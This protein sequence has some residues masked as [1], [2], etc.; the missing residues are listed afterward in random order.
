[1]HQLGKAMG[2]EL[3]KQ[4]EHIT[5]VAKKTDKVD[6]EIARNRALLDRF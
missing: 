4:N 1:M 3:D 6:D 5:R 2:T